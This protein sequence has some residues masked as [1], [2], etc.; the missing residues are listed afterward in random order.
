MYRD[1]G[2]EYKVFIEFHKDV[3]NNEEVTNSYK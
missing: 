1:Y 2:Q 3:M